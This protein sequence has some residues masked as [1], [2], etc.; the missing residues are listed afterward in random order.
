[1]QAWWQEA[2]GAKIVRDP[3]HDSNYDTG[4]SAARPFF[5]IHDIEGSAGSA[6][7]KFR[8]KDAG[9]STQFVVDGPIAYQM[10]SNLDTAWGCG[11]WYYNQRGVQAEIPG[12]AGRPYNLTDIDT[13]ARL[14]AQWAKETGYPIR[15]LN[16]AEISAKLPG[17]F[18]HEDV[19]NPDNPLK[20][21][22]K[23]GHT[24]PGPTFPWSEFIAR[25][26][27]YYEKGGG[28][29]VIPV[30]DFRRFDGY[31]WPTGFAIDGNF[32]RHWLTI[33]G[34]VPAGSV[35]AATRQYGYPLSGAIGWRG[36]TVQWFERARLELHPGGEITM[37]RVGAEF[38]DQVRDQAPFLD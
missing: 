18:G 28:T 24:D 6:R 26:Q 37:G 31:K 4:G 36:L 30:A 38:Y 35:V 32:I 3:A 17:V 9:G 12:Y 15:K 14:C 29:A 23:E 2:M 20:F 16:R 19:P 25:A 27:G 22:G 8:N 33:G 13:A 7:N 11:N 34:L 1:M 21:G 10:V 5:I